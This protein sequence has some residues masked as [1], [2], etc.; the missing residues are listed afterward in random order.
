MSIRSSWNPDRVAAASMAKKSHAPRRTY[1]KRPA[2]KVMK[3]SDLY[4]REYGE[5]AYYAWKR[6]EAEIDAL[7]LSGRCGAAE[8]IKMRADNLRQM[9]AAGASRGREMP[10]APCANLH[11]YTSAA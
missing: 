4:I 9:K 1:N 7:W 6:R 8:I 5:K 11:T 10:D 3:V 2:A